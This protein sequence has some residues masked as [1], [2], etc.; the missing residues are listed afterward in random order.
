M[1][2]LAGEEH[3][4]EEAG[5]GASGTLLDWFSLNEQCPHGGEATP[6]GRAEG[7][8]PVQTCWRK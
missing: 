1:V 5:M 6:V 8:S 3:E 7:D 2:T 4:G